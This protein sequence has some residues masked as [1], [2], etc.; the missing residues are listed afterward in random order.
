MEQQY[1]PTSPC[2]LKLQEAMSGKLR[3]FG[4][5]NGGLREVWLA[6]RSLLSLSEAAEFGGE[7]SRT[8]CSGFA[9]DHRIL[10]FRGRITITAN[11]KTAI[12]IKKHLTITHTRHT[13]LLLLKRLICTRSHRR[14]K[15]VDP[16]DSEFW[17]GLF[18]SESLSR[19]VHGFESRWFPLEQSGVALMSP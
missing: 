7:G 19:P 13:R 14:S 1:G 12:G 16:M 5:E 2:R 3:L 6:K 11:Q 4:K 17:Q 9:S 8:L 10:R 18:S 15:V